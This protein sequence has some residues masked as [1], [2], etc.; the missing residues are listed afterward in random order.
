MTYDIPLVR[1][2]PPS[3]SK[4][5]KMLREIEQRGIFSNYG[6]VNTQ[7]EDQL[8]AQL[9]SGQGQC[10][11]VNNATIGLMIAIR[12]AIGSPGSDRCYALM[13]S[14][15]FA[16]AAQAAMWCGLTPLLCDVDPQNWAAAP[17]EEEALLRK[18]GSKIAVIV[19]YA[20]FGFDIDLKRY[21]IMSRKWSVP[22]VIDA[23]AS[24]GTL[25]EDGR[26]F[27]TG[28][29]GTVVFSMHATKSFATAEGGLIYSANADTIRDLRAM[30][31]FGFGQVRHATMPGLNG[32]MSEVG[33]LLGLM[34]LASYDKIMDHRSAL[35]Q[36]YRRLL[37]DL[38][39]QT[40]KRNR[41]AHQFATALLPRGIMSKRLSIQEGLRAEGIGSG[42]Y[43]SP[44]IAQQDFFADKAVWHS[45]DVTDDVAERMIS[46][47]LFD[48]M[49]KG[50]VRIVCDALRRQ[51]D[52]A[53]LEADQGMHQLMTRLV[54]TASLVQHDPAQ[55]LCVRKS[56]KR[57]RTRRFPTSIPKEPAALG[58]LETELIL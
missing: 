40:E 12:H 27:G 43:F 34:R 39:F 26:G 16:A 45:L 58:S 46:L 53:W 4:A 6:P 18:Y 49:T 36:E 2:K 54:K 5:G 31:N 11:T 44:H 24:L 55:V 47:P 56:R 48:K 7:L 14:F 35:V 32:K 9:F 17:D 51:M 28:F 21:E 23:A 57:L 52:G 25:Q 1:P 22:V 37:P 3:L 29:S 33:A 30:S 13:P 20:S 42:R 10:L 19:P 41:Q 15:T 50:Q 38:S 8:C